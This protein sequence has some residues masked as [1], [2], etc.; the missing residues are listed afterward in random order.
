MTDS[1][2]QC[3]TKLEY[4]RGRLEMQHETRFSTR[5]SALQALDKPAHLLREPE[6]GVP[7]HNQGRLVQVTFHYNVLWFDI[8]GYQSAPSKCYN[9]FV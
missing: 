9:K 6:K 1:W 7:L 2:N 5:I 8:E 3:H 4:S